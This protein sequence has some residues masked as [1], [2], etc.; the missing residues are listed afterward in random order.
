LKW[1]P[2]DENSIDFRLNLQFPPST[3][4]NPNNVTTNTPFADIPVGTIFQLSIF[5]GRANDNKYMKWSD[6]YVPKQD[7]EKIQNA[8]IDFQ[9]ENSIVECRWDKKVGTSGRWRFMRFRTDKEHA[10]YIDVAK[11]VQESIRDGVTK[12][13]LLSW[14]VDIKRGWRTRNPRQ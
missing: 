7:W 2:D 3:A 13:E 5:Q 1:K 9:L 14:A 8:E 11:N 6:M 4:L 12:E 10:N